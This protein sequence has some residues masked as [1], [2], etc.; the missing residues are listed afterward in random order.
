MR[1]ILALPIFAVFVFLISFSM[2]D[3]HATTFEIQDQGSCN[4]VGGTWYPASS[5]NLPECQITD[6]T[7][8]LHTGDT[9]Q[10]DAGI[11]VSL[12]GM[13]NQGMINNYGLIVPINTANSFPVNNYGTINNLFGGVIDVF[14]G[15][16]LNNMV[17][18]T[19]YNNHGAT[20]HI[21]TDGFINNKGTVVN[22]LGTIINTIDGNAPVGC[23]STTTISPKLNNLTLG[24]PVTL[25]A[26]VTDPVEQ[27]NGPPTGTVSWSTGGTGTFN[28]TSCTLTGGSCSVSFTQ[29]QLGSATIAAKYGE[30]AIDNSSSDS[31]TTVV[32]V[33]DPNNQNSCQ[34]I[35]GS[36]DSN[37]N[38]C[39]VANLTIES[40]DTL[41]IDSTKAL[42][43]SGMITNAG[44]VVNNGFMTGTGQFI[45]NA[46][47]T[48]TNNNTFNPGSGSSIVNSGTIIN[49]PQG[50]GMDIFG[51]V[52]NSGK[53]N[54]LGSFSTTSSISNTGDI[55]NSQ[56]LSTSN[57]LDNHG[58]ITNSG[59]LH[60]FP[61]GILNNYGTLT[62]NNSI[63]NDGTLNNYCGTII[64]SISGNQVRNQ[65]DSIPPTLSII[66]P[67]INVALDHL[68]AVNGTASDDTSVSSVTGKI[69]NGGVSVAMTSDS[70]ANWSFATTGLSTG[71]HTIEINATDSANLVTS[72]S[73]SIIIN[74]CQP[75]RYL[76]NNQ[77][78]PAPAGS[79]VPTAG[80][81][82]ATQCPA[83]S[84]TSAEGQSVCTPSPSG[85][86]VGTA[87][88]T[89]ATQCPAE[90]YCPTL[91]MSTPLTCPA[92]DFC[93]TGSVSPD[94]PP[95]ISITS[96]TNGTTINTATVQVSGTASDDTSVSSVSWKVDS[97]QVST[98]TGITSWS[99]TTG[100][101]SAGPHTIQVNATDSVGL[102]T[103]S[104]ISITY[105]A[106]T[107]TI[108][109]PS[110]TG[111][112]SFNTNSGGFTA[113]NSILQSDL[114]T[115]PP[116][117]SYPLGFFSWSITNFAPATSVTITITSPITLPS[118]SQY[119]KLVGGTWV[120]IPVNVSGNTMTMTILDN[121]P[122]DGNLAVGTISDPGAVADPTNGRLTGEGKIG[123]GTDFS[124]EIR[125]DIDK[126]TT[127]GNLNYQDKSTNIKLHSDNVSF[128]SVDASMTQATI[129]GTGD[130]DKNHNDYTFIASVTDPDKTGDHDIF[131]IT[132][133]DS[134]G[135]VVYQNTGTVKG[136]IEIHKFADHDDKSDSGV[137]HGNNGNQ[138]DNGKGNG[139]ND[140]GHNNSH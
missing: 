95:T 69:D 48:I 88:A 2:P 121:G 90:T 114:L 16:A 52:S 68:S 18:G 47:G 74:D 137:K 128:L 29:N 123:Q 39:T 79:Y 130:L 98:A 5:L 125:S 72:Q 139:G 57:V 113:L 140:K 91:G 80:A 19:I 42:V 102:V 26:T 99:F 55:A 7:F 20:I 14:S 35:G 53:I 89:S 10:I 46:G 75:G 38:T 23:I 124:F 76:S 94:T 50:D 115:L 93:A 1:K 61:T 83:G 66:Q 6:N 104:S 24:S 71:L 9:M 3:A 81:T 59:T 82:S 107:D 110:G 34:L 25:T 15:A 112:I 78:I 40:G 60:L 117:G 109:P 92:G 49:N 54:N 77:C 84:F 129:S 21:D 100:T 32:S 43:N 64:G 133:T 51:S 17:G 96:P 126:S 135:K 70:F 73:I 13:T 65:C 27:I 41:Q 45:N 87:G 105:A 122:L 28:P 85:S 97:G 11:E 120:S 33:I 132:I 116:P 56:F 119:F 44:D 111:Q 138:N 108:P 86:F 134:Y 62:N 37:A 12:Y 106:P 101:L 4:S 103:T 63:T 30:S 31:F 131:S 67:S 136:H 118:Q 36:W 8:S 58:T 22:C 127:K